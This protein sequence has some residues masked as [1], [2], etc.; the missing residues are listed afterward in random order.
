MI[1]SKGTFGSLRC[2]SYSTALL[3]DLSKRKPGGCN[4]IEIASIEGIPLFNSDV[5]TAQD[6]PH[7]ISR[8]KE[9]IA[10]ADG[11]ILVSPEYNHSIPGVARNAIDWLSRSNSDIRIVFRSEPIAIAGASPGSFG[12]DFAQNAWLPAFITLG[13]DNWSGGH[14]AV[15]H[16]GSDVGDHGD[17]Q[18][19][20][21]MEH[22]PKIH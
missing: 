4:N 14:L 15:S 22:I 5:E 1:D 20:A 17:V 6:F 8:L 13:A 21:T 2:G 9:E 3:C 7:S 11:P 18:D 12:N 10:M 16:A 19:Q